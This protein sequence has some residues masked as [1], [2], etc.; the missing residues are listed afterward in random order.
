MESFKIFIVEDDRLYGEL[1]AFNLSLN[2]D[3]EVELFT[4]GQECVSNLY[5]NPSAISLDYSLPDM[6]GF[7]VLE[8]IKK[9]NPEIP[10][11]IVSGQEDVSTAVGL[12]KKGAYDYIVKDEDT[13]DRLWNC[14]KNIRENLS[15]KKEIL[16]LKEEIGKKY[17]FT[18][19]I[20]GNSPS[21]QKAFRLMEKATKTNITV[22]ISGETGT[23]K[24]L[25]AK[26]IHYNSDRAK[27]PFVAVNMTAIP[28]ELIESELFGHE[29]GAFTGA[30]IRRI[31]KFEEAHKGT[32]FLDEIAEMDLSLQSKILRVLQEKEVT[33]VGGNQVIK[34]DVR[35]IVATHKNLAE[36]VKKGNFREDLYYRLL[37][38]PIELPPLRERGND[39]L[40]LAK[41]FVDEFCKENKLPKLTFTQAAQEKLMK[42]PFPGNVRELKA[43]VELASVMTNNNYIDAE[44]ITFNS[45]SQTTDFLLEENTLRTYIQQIVSHYLKKYDNNIVLVAQKLDIGKST[46]YR[47]L[48]NGEIEL[49]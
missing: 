30:A 12:L 10:V 22:S 20:K 33:R 45:A 36:E 31:G 15:L 49:N 3:Y 13:K 19:V 7:E 11:V 35:V 39:I 32:I 14:M 26:A 46:I 24:E 1:L 28:R 40:I 25:V 27:K 23:G 5:K 2:P 6:T 9:Y 21:I 38:L 34:L 17:E 41:Y 43:V 29:K 18:S 47:M 42:Y 44:D 4:T 48:K 8:K 16:E 37:G